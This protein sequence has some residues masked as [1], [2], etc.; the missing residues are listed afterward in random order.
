[1][2]FVKVEYL[3][4]DQVMIVQDELTDLYYVVFESAQNYSFSPD[5]VSKPYKSLNGVKAAFK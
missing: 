5:Y 4:K 2:K 3:Y 1:M